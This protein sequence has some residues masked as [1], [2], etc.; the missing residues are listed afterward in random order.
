MIWIQWR[1]DK[2]SGGEEKKSLNP[3]IEFV[4][5]YSNGIEQEYKKSKE[6]EGIKGLID[7]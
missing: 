1:K 3:S 6:M 7:M 5:K 2:T 4:E